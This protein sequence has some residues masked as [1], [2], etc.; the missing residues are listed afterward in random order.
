MSDA[1]S[2]KQQT[3]LYSDINK[4]CFSTITATTDSYGQIH[5]DSDIISKIFAIF[6]ECENK[7]L[8]FALKSGMSELMVFA[9]TNTSLTNETIKHVTNTKVTIKIIYFK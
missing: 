6:V 5:I 4:I 2:P 8:S 1:L 7:E 9:V 3:E